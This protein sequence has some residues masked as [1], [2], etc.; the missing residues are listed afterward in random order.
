MW[1]YLLY[2]H[3]D[4]ATRPEPALRRAL[5]QVHV[6]SNRVALLKTVAFYQ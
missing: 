1:A 6:S 3:C 4:F 5:P 2:S